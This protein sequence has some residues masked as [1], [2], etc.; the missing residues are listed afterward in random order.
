MKLSKGKL[1]LLY[2]LFL[3]C[4]IFM[5]APQFRPLAQY[6]PLQSAPIAII[7]PYLA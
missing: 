1:S 7:G 5:F 2:P 4:F 6:D 3:L